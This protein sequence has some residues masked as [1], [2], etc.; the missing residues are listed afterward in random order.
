M[1]FN[2]GV[3]KLI[4]ID[5]STGKYRPCV[6]CGKNVSFAGCGSYHRPE[7]V[8]K[9]ISKGTRQQGQRDSFVP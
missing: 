3:K 1:P 4:V 6:M 5:K 7:G 8:E 2:Q 9:S